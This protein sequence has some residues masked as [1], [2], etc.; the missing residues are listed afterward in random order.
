LKRDADA[1]GA[2]PRRTES[3]GGLSRRDFINT[4]VV[5]ATGLVVQ[6]WARGEEKGGAGKQGADLEIAFIG[7]GSQGRNLLA[8]CLKVPGIRI[9]ALCDIWPYHQRY[10]T[11]ILK[12][13][14]QP[15]TVYED[16]RELL[17]KEKN[18][19]AAIIATPDWVH[20]EQTNAA[21]RAGLHVYCEKEMSNT[22]EAAA[23]MVRTAQE[24]GKLLQ[25]GH[26]RRSN[27][28]YWLALKLIEKERVVGRMTHAYGQWNRR[29]GLDV[30]W[31]KG[32]EMDEAALKRYGYES[33]E[34]FRN[35][36]WYHKYSGGPLADLGSHQIDV[37]SWFLKADPVAVLASGG[38]DYYREKGRDWYDNMM[39]IYE[40]DTHQRD[41]AGADVAQR[42]R[43]FYQVLNTTSQGGYY[44]TFMGDEGSIVISED[45]NKGFFFREPT[46]TARR[47]WEDEAKKVSAMGRDAIQIKLGESLSAKGAKD[48]KAEK[49]LADVQKPVHQLHLENFFDAVRANKKELLTC[50]AETAYR[51]AVA[52][53]V[54]NEAAAA[55]RQLEF[56]P[57]QFKV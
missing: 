48:P 20:A 17:A 30:G 14:N 40:Y 55:K 31:A 45:V 9:R 8:N 37:F 43:S 24:T 44:E 46:S 11:G 18:L 4:A 52:V 13:Y 47:Q 12:A 56:K 28:R 15:A 7:V 22:L 57:E 35:W 38:L 29:Q 10:A 41:A 16:Y 6:S 53:L 27:P 54:A 36:R 2:D 25:V 51:T 3:G 32:V 49:L 5:A 26:Q 1:R 42:V 39:T 23:S 19:A 34:Q 33:M 21:L 50:P